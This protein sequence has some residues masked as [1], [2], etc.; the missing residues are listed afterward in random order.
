MNKIYFVGALLVFGLLS[1]C[2][3]D[4]PN[5]DKDPVKIEE[6]VKKDSSNI[7]VLFDETKFSSKIELDLLKELGLGMCNPNEKDLKNYKNPAC[8]P[9]FFKFF[10]FKKDTPIKNGF[11]LLVKSMVHEF[12]LRR[13]FVFQ[14]I[15]NKLVKVNGFIANLIAKRPSST[16][17]DDLVLRFR[18]EEQNF[19][20]CVYSWR[21]NHY[22]FDRVEQINDANIKPVFQDSMNLEIEKMI[23]LNRMQF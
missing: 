9:K 2:K 4:L 3:T 16:I 6:K 12:P 23:E 11:L 7:E 20:N 1:A 22:E 15:D 21:N 19:F 18:D 10:T 14:R 8:D 17:Y 13:L 5:T